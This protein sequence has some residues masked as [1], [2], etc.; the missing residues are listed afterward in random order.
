M[1]LYDL[2]QEITHT[3]RSQFVEK[4]LNVKLPSDYKRFI[5]TT[6]F[7][8]DERGEIFGHS[9]AIKDIYKIPCVIGATIQYR[10]DYPNITSKEVVISFDNYKNTPIV[11]NTTTGKVYRVYHNRK[12]L[13]SDNFKEFLKLFLA[14]KF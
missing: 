14:G 2:L 12:E 6:G 10:K 11:L 9:E 1:I 13:V 5:D 8:S 7:I 3:K 4:A